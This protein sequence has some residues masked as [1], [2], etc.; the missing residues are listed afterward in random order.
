MS[1]NFSAELAV[2]VKLGK[3][4]QIRTVSEEVK[5]FKEDT[6]E[7]YMFTKNKDVAFFCGKPTDWETNP[8]DELES[9]TDLKIGYDH[10]EGDEA[11]WV[12]GKIVCEA[13]NDSWSKTKSI[14][15]VTPEQIEAAKKE[16]FEKLSKFGF[17]EPHMIGV[18]LISYVSY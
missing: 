18:Y 12:L 2:G 13:D 3:V 14:V 6:G 16:V 9:K 7:P 4:W 5:K 11:D 15:E 1:V 17:T 8:R 10:R